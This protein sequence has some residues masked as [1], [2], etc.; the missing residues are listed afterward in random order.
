MAPNS[1]GQ[2]DLPR[3]GVIPHSHLLPWPCYH[4]ASVQW[5]ARTRSNSV[6][7]VLLQAQKRM[8]GMYALVSSIQ[9][10]LSPISAFPG[11]ISAVAGMGLSFTNPAPR[12][13]EGKTS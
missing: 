8:L 5:G 12:D 9:D 11:R 3:E 7:L 4:E 1:L 13:A 2:R 10:Y 6:S